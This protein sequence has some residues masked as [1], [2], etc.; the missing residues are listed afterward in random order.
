MS[1][2]FSRGF[3]HY[4]SQLNTGKNLTYRC[5]RKSYITGLK[6]YLSRSNDLIKTTGHSSNA[7]VESN[8]IDKV[9]MA[10]ALRNFC[11][12][13]DEYERT[14]ELA[15]VREKANAKQTQINKEV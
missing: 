15:E 7:I 6:I 11:V 2:V 1:D 5:L 9:E 3:T 4:Y 8:Y 12:F 14:K 13:P 10:K